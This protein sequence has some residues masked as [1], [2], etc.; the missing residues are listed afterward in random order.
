MSG[1]PRT[2]WSVRPDRRGWR[3]EE[4]SYTCSLACPPLPGSSCPRL[5][6]P[7]LSGCH[8]Q[9]L[10]VAFGHAHGRSPAWQSS[11]PQSLPEFQRLFPDDAACAATWR[12]LAGATGLFAPL[13]QAAGEPF[14]FANR[15]GVLRCRKC[16]RDT[17]LTV[18]TVMAALA[19]AAERMVLVCLS[20]GPAK[21]PACRLCSFGDN[22]ACRAT[23]RRSKSS[24]SSARGWCA[25]IRT[26]SVAGPAI[27]V[28]VDETWGW[29]PDARQ[30]AWRPR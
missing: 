12:R 26:G 25:R 28:E 16:R 22:L 7:C 23:R 17:G 27:T 9:P 21:H 4:M 8:P 24:T 6:V 14:R 29:R 13:A 15:L 20:G 3:Y 2:G 5:L 30:R 11:V 19:H 10:A 1:Y 18:G